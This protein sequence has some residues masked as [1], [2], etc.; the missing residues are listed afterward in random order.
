MLPL[1]L[2]NELVRGRRLVEEAGVFILRQY[3]AVLRLIRCPFQVFGY[4]S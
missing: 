4:C 3:F 1:L 2:A